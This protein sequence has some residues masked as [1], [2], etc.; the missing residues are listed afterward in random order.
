MMKK[1]SPGGIFAKH[2][3]EILENGGTPLDILGELK[4]ASKQAIS[5]W[6]FG[7]PAQPIEPQTEEKLSAEVI[8]TIDDIIQILH[9]KHPQIDTFHVYLYEYDIPIVKGMSNQEELALFSMENDD[10]NSNPKLREDCQCLQC[11]W[12]EYRKLSGT[13]FRHVLIERYLEKKTFIQDKY[14]VSF[15]II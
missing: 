13:N 7:E 5:L 8:S 1:D 15:F 6:P 14:Q 12:G 3:S 2:L 4:T 9:D 11:I 10:H